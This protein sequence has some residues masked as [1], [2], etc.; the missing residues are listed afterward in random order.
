VLRRL[1]PRSAYDLMAMMALFLALTTGAV[2]A[3]NEW[4][5]ANIVDESLTAAD[6]RGK[7]AS[8][9]T[10]GVNGSLGTAE[11]AGQPNVV[12][13]G[14]PY[15]NGSLTTWDIA[16]SAIRGRDVLDGT[17]TGDDV[18]E[19]SLGQMTPEVWHYIGDPGEPAFENGWSNY[20][21]NPT[22]TDAVYQHV[23]YMKDKNGVVHIR[24]LA[25]GGTVGTAMFELSYTYCPWFF[26][27]FPVISNNAFAR[28]TV[29]YVQPW[30]NVIADAGTS[31]LWVSLEGVS[32]QEHP[33]ESRTTGASAP[34]EGAAGPLGLRR[35][36]R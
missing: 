25:D 12:A 26:H 5:G 24:G 29:E 23:A 30:C 13:A 20:D 18:D 11:I 8:G 3:A 9:T 33:L 36:T 17:I 6:V 10:P 27:A 1:F 2:Y 7:S 31:N 21:T 19:S 16:D 35:S 34:R 14:Q 4:T 15:I 28:V 22:H 32:Y